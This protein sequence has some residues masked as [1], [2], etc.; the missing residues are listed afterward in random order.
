MKNLDQ[1]LSKLVSNYFQAYSFFHIESAEYHMDNHNNY[2]T[3]AINGF[4]EK[5]ETL[6]VESK[7]ILEYVE[8]KE[9]FSFN[10]V[11]SETKK[12]DRISTFE[13]C[14]LV[15]DTFNTAYITNSEPVPVNLKTDTVSVVA[16]SSR[17]NRSEKESEIL[18]S[19][20]I[21][22]IPKACNPKKFDLAGAKKI[23][24]KRKGAKE[25]VTNEICSE[26]RGSISG[27]FNSSCKE[28]IEDQSLIAITK[29]MQVKKSK[30]S[31]SQSIR[32]GHSTATQMD[33]YGGNRRSSTSKCDATQKEIHDY[34]EAIYNSTL[35]NNK[36]YATNNQHNQSK[37]QIVKESDFNFDKHTENYYKIIK[38]E[39]KEIRR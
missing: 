6:H 28:V 37:A 15:S 34:D 4:K 30:L 12:K 19:T 11:I 39:M 5:A 29:I 38:N 24:L 36:S 10:P 32:R 16:E 26:E 2:F 33:Y 18:G 35:E 20:K 31:Q 25:I 9:E 27:S 14:N 17:R 3:L 22:N 8:T 1:Q 21:S 7:P 23:Q 13:I